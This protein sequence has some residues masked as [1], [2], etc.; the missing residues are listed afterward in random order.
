M[1]RTRKQR[2]VIS[3]GRNKTITAL[4][5]S[6]GRKTFGVVISVDILVATH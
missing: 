5:G 3:E 4:L 1:Q 2:T 6:V